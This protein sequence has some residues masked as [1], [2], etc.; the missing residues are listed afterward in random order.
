[1]QDGDT[2]RV[3]G[4]VYAATREGYVLPVIDVTNPHF[5][6]PDDAASVDALFE[7][8]AAEERK[9]RRLPK[10]L[11][12]PMLKLMARRSLLLKAIV[13]SGADFLDGT[14]T[15]IMKLG[16][17]NLPPPF[18]QP[19]DR[20]LAA[21]PHI[22]LLRLRTLQ[23][24]RLIAESVAGDLAAA[25]GAPLHLINIGGGPAIDSINTLILLRRDRPDL[26]RRPLRIHVLDGDE[27]GPYFGA[28]ALAALQAEGR[29]LSGL[30]IAF[31][32]IA[33]DWNQPA[34]LDRLVR[35]LASGPAVIAA[36]SE[37]ALF[38][39]GS[40]EAIIANLKA[41]APAGT[42]SRLI[43]GSVTRADL[44]RRR[45]MRDTKF[46]LYPRGIEGFAPLVEAAGGRIVRSLSAGLSDQVLLRVG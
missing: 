1:M 17:D 12:R 27:A 9:R 32:R 40:D 34:V 28:N 45:M 21:S 22:G 18:D 25:E 42:G 46:K 19:L 39:Y 7:R 13:G 35:Q 43:A 16:A 37:G 30:D 23:T 8:F 29:P 26:V 6:M 31:E 2:R 38:E 44:I 33:Y 36:M 5:A 11:M 20:K 10:F 24:A 3:E 15:Y 41:L 14:T 4:V